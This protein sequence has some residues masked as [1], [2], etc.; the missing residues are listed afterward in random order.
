MGLSAVMIPL[1]LVADKRLMVGYVDYWNRN[2]CVN[3]TE[4]GLS[5]LY[6]LWAVSMHVI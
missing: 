6:V 1:T 3:I 2:M 4:T 5:M